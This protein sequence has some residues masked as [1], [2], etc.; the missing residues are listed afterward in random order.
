MK[1]YR[2]SRISQQNVVTGT[3]LETCD[4]SFLTVPIDHGW[5]LTLIEY[6]GLV[7]KY[8]NPVS[9]RG[10]LKAVD[11]DLMWFKVD[12]DKDGANNATIPFPNNS[13][14]KKRS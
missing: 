9:M 12:G 6:S 4:N 8:S 2:L 14:T 1:K 3:F 7:H 11:V 10:T 13:H 5:G